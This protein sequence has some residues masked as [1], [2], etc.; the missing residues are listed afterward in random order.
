MWDQI[1]D[2]LSQAS[3][4]IVSG[5]ANFLPGLLALLVIL[6]FTV[7]IIAMLRVG[8]RRFLRSIEFDG[9]VVR[10]GFPDV[11]EWSPRRSPTLL[12]IRVVSWTIFIVGFLAGISA[13]DA[14]LPSMLVVRLFGYIPNVLAAVLVLAVGIFAARLLGRSVLISAVN[15]RLQ[16][17]RLVSLGVKWL[18]LVLAGAMA[19]EHLG[20]G[21]NIVTLSFAILF[22][23]IVLALSLAVGLGSKDMVSRSWEQQGQTEKETEEH[24]HHL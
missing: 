23:G 4:R 14:A 11:A 9:R 2:L 6:L 12:V 7:A 8:L 15:M 16:S 13:L 19:L 22:G 10:W 18:V 17:A 1:H 20:I 21:G 24:V 3:Y 5:V